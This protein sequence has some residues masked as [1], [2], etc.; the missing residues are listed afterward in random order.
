MI[1]LGLTGSIAMGKTTVAG[2]FRDEGVPV[3]DS[4]AVVHRL[5]EPGGAGFEPVGE[6]FPDC[7]SD[8]RIDREALGRAVFGDAGGRR[9]L[10]GILH[11]LVR[12]DRGEWLDARRAEGATKVVLDPT[13]S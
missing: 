3:H 10:E 11:P 7:V 2:M 12:A 1:V 6:A 8:G 4:D 13:A 9:R 5:V